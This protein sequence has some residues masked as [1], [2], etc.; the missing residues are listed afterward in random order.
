MPTK[1]M[2][3]PDELLAEA[4]AFV[5]LTDTLWETRCVNTICRRTATPI[6]FSKPLH[7]RIDYGNLRG[8]R[9]S[10]TDE[11]LP[12]PDILFFVRELSI[13]TSVSRMDHRNFHDAMQLVP[14]IPCLFSNTQR[15]TV[16]GDGFSDSLTEQ[17]N[18]LVLDHLVLFPCLM[19]LSMNFY[20]GKLLISI[21]PSQLTSLTLAGPQ[22]DVLLDTF[23]MIFDQ[24]P[25][26]EE[27]N[28]CDGNKKLGG[29]DLVDWVQTVMEQKNKQYLNIKRMS[30]SFYIRYDKSDVHVRAALLAF[31]FFTL[32]R[33]ERL[34]LK[35]LNSITRHITR[36]DLSQTAPYLRLSPEIVKRSG[37][38]FALEIEQSNDFLVDHVEQ[39]NPLYN[40]LLPQPYIQKL[41]L[42]LCQ[43]DP[44][45]P[46]LHCFPHSG[47]E[48][49]TLRDIPEE[50]PWS[51]HDDEYD[52]PIYLEELVELMTLMPRLSNVRLED[53]QLHPVEDQDLASLPHLTVEDCYLRSSRI[54]SP[55]FIEQ[56]VT[57]CPQLT[58]LTMHDVNFDEDNLQ[59]YQPPIIDNPWMPKLRSILKGSL[60]AR[61]LAIPVINLSLSISP[62]K[63]ALYLILQDQSSANG[64]PLAYLGQYQQKERDLFPTVHTLTYRETQWLLE[65]IDRIH[66]TDGNVSAPSLLTD[67]SAQIWDCLKRRA[68]T[69]IT[70]LSLN[71]K[72]FR[73]GNVG[74]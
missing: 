2:D 70:C 48:D 61:W 5:V 56:L 23:I 6:A 65:L 22:C 15:L 7:H 53:M 40:D 17:I 71:Q 44:Q 11:F 1:M 38:P 18:K 59:V 68:I 13:R 34:D 45:H 74:P 46:W 41:T 49:L 10:S 72:A 12:T 52:N 3:L 29:Q 21:L 63:S 54:D 24:L 36:H 32:P 42:N 27:L 50:L 31:M 51:V 37:Q 73:L 30:F 33:L 64:M 39:P 4:F 66:G 20:R 19:E 26:L 60:H 16:S 55:A 25:H 14:T 57:V 28:Y 62:P 35:I 69:V 9:R 43:L 8:L 47:V 67:T 58:D